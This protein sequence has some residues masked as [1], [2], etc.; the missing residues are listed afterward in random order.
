MLLYGYSTCTGNKW[1]IN[2]SDVQCF[3]AKEQI[4]SVLNLK[5]H[6][7]YHFK[8]SS[9][10]SPYIANSEAIHVKGIFLPIFSAFEEKGGNIS[11][12]VVY[13]DFIFGT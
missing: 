3:K 6:K 2:A 1:E 11:R 5:L 4:F 12:L 10:I 9:Y 7:H 8:I 13:Y